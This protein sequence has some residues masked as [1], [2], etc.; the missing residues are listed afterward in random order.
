MP[1]VREDEYSFGS[2]G[3]FPPTESMHLISALSLWIGHT[4]RK[5]VEG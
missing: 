5:T 4:L 3:V 1:K 2:V